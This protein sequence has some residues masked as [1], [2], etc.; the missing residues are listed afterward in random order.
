MRIANK[1]TLIVTGIL[2]LGLFGCMS[3]CG[4]DSVVDLVLTSALPSS[5]MDEGMESGRCFHFSTKKILPDASKEVQYKCNLADNCVILLD[6]A[7]EWANRASNKYP[8]IV[9]KVNAIIEQG[10]HH[11]ANRKVNVD[12]KE[13]D[14]NTVLAV[15]NE[16]LAVISRLPAEV[17]Q[18]PAVALRVASF[19]I[20]IVF[21]GNNDPHKRPPGVATVLRSVNGSMQELINQ[22]TPEVMNLK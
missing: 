7:K 21:T 9:A 18:Q 10:K 6:A 22:L 5:A 16:T 8:Q 11:L 15:S 2:V 13:S 12:L 17:R 1:T 3:W 20:S 19:L 14:V 4:E